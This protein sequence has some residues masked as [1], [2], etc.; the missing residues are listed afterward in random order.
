MGA[1]VI[2]TSSADNKL[3]IAKKL[4]A[5]ELVNYKT[6]PEWGDEV[7]R[8][9]NGRGV[10]LVAEVGGTG[11]VEES[12]KSLRQGGTAFLIGSLAPP[13]LVDLVSPLLI[14]GK[15]CKCYPRQYICFNRWDADLKTVKGI[16]AFS[17]KM[18]EQVVD[19]VE[20]HDLHPL[21]KVYEWEDA[22]E[23]FEQM[24]GQDFV[25]KIVIKV[26]IPIDSGLIFSFASSVLIPGSW[27]NAAV[28]CAEGKHTWAEGKQRLNTPEHTWACLSRAW[29]QLEP[30]FAL[31]WASRTRPESAWAQ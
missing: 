2:A 12:I 10:D 4:G 5:S 3:E 6:T 23:A 1:K 22:K 29:A 13:K 17:R 28:T 8:I 16:I 14:K 27:A 24:K 26:W 30:S 19:L 9:T 15:T 21:I 7:L 18:L 31:A 20:K 11:T 25:G